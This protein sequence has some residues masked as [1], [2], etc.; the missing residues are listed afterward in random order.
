[1]GGVFHRHPAEE[2]GEGEAQ[3]FLADLASMRPIQ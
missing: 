3:D 1:V 2:L